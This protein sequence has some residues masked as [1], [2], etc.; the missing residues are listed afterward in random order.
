MPSPLQL[1]ATMLFLLLL[2]QA[3]GVSCAQSGSFN[4]A[5]KGIMKLGLSSGS[6][7]GYIYVPSQYDP[8][9]ANAMILAIHAAGRGGLDA[10]QLLIASANSTGKALVVLLLTGRY[11]LTCLAA[12]PLTDVS[13]CEGSCPFT[14]STCECKAKPE[15]MLVCRHHSAGSRLT[16][17]HV[18]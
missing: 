8:T 5:Q 3:H 17:R 4:S 2:D 7:D 15:E 12:T 6:R 10:L 16:R 9:K 18:G 13:S 14:T 1:L 11:M